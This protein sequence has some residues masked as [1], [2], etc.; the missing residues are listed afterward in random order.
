MVGSRRFRFHLPAF[1]LSV[2]LLMFAT[3]SVARGFPGFAPEPRDFQVIVQTI[4]LPDGTPADVYAPDI[5]RG[6]TSKFEDRLPVVVLL[7]GALVD[8]DFYSEY[9]QIIAGNGY[10]VVVPNRERAV[11]PGYTA[12]FADVHAVTDAIDGMVVEDTDPGSPFFRV[13]DTATVALIGHS[14]GGAVAIDA[15]AG[16]CQPPFCDPTRGPFFQPPGLKA[17]VAYG[18]SRVD[19][20]IDKDGNIIACTPLSRDTSGV[21]VLLIQGVNDGIAD[22][23]KADA[24]LP[25]LESPHALVQIPGATHFALCNVAQPPPPVT[26]ETNVSELDQQTAIALVAEKTLDWLEMNLE[27]D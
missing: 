5:P 16:V 23:I 19:C 14:F 2:L 17:A 8:K 22:P 4:D 25:E 13:T 10:V 20:Q 27:A 18:A 9:A 1:A 26:V 24:T 21:A 6:L 7:Q 15:A 11:A 3:Q 12:L